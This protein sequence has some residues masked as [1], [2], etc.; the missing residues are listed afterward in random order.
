MDKITTTLDIESIAAF[1]GS[2]ECSKAAQAILKNSSGAQSFKNT[3]QKKKALDDYPE[4]LN[5]SQVCEIIGL[6]KSTFHKKLKNGELENF[7]R[8]KSGKLRSKFEVIEWTRK[9]DKV[10]SGERQISITEIMDKAFG[11]K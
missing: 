6:P 11:D 8:F 10:Q 7:P 9:R 1:V 5:V 4:L 3:E 2:E